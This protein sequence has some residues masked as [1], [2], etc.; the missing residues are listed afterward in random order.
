MSDESGS[1]ALYWPGTL[2]F[3][4]GTL[5]RSSEYLGVVTD[6]YEGNTAGTSDYFAAFVTASSRE[7][8][9]F[10]VDYGS[11][12]ALTS[13]AI[14][15]V[16]PS[17]PANFQYTYAGEGFTIPV[18]FSAAVPEAST[19]AM[20]MVGF[21]VSSAAMRRRPRRKVAMADLRHATSFASGS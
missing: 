7:S 21:G 17:G 2:S 1:V 10:Y 13:S 18:T 6:G 19:W 4:S 3:Q 8:Y 14:P 15:S 16:L 5:S 11:T 20:M 12:A 9:G